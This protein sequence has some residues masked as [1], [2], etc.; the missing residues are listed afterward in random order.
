M[1]GLKKKGEIKS[2]H[3]RVEDQLHHLWLSIDP[4]C[5]RRKQNWHKDCLG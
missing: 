3:S 5:V 2:D 1:W 4:G